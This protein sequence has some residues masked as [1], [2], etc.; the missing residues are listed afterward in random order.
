MKPGN[1]RKRGAKSGGE[2]KMRIRYTHT[3]NPSVCAFC[4]FGELVTRH[5]IVLMNERIRTT[6]WKKDCLLLNV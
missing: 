4:F 2:R 6:K 1:L 5:E 3:S